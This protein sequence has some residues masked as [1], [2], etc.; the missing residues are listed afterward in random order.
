MR[1]R[2]A[3]LA[4]PGRMEVREFEVPAPGAGE[5]LVRMKMASICGSDLHAVF[6]GFHRGRFGEPGYPGH[7]GVGEVVESGAPGFAPGQAVL[8][9]PAPPAARCFAEYLL[10]DAAYLV[11]LPDGG[12][13]GRLLLAQQLGTTIYAMRK[14]WPSPDGMAERRVATVVGAGSAGLFFVQQLRQVGFERIVVSDLDPERLAM[15]RELGADVVVHAPR[16][17]VIDATMDVSGGVGADLAIEAAG[18]DDCRAECV[19]A[20]R[21]RGRVGCFG[22]PQRQ[23]LAPFPVETAFRKAPT[24][25][26]FVGTQH[27]PGLRSFREAVAA[28]H[29]GRIEVGYCLRPRFPLERV[30]DAFALAEARTGAIKVA[31]EL[32]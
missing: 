32:S 20:V 19:E 17:S 25:E 12:D 22:Y 2:A 8:T 31:I 9:V 14:F 15:A 7:E 16:E 6:D 28:I 3:A 18:Y 29:D 1:M 11:P 30:A 21:S 27:E 23:G 24:V 10:V 4:A 5:V 26:F 13:P